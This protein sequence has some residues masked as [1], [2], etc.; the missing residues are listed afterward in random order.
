[1]TSST[2]TPSGLAM[3]WVSENAFQK[4]VPNKPAPVASREKIRGML[5]DTRASAL[6][7]GLDERSYHLCRVSR[8]TSACEWDRVR[9]TPNGTFSPA[10]N[11]LLWA[12]SDAKPV[13]EIPNL[14]RLLDGVTGTG[15]MQG[16][17]PS[18]ASRSIISRRKDFWGSTRS[19]PRETQRSCVLASGSDTYAKAIENS[20]ST[21]AIAA[22]SDVLHPGRGRG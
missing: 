8:T 6:A 22:V 15:G 18:V 2:S 19:L 11:L 16:A 7:H 20:K 4:S 14:Q 13:S 17:Q 12:M 1:M 3:V 5:Q 9:R 21:Q 10:S